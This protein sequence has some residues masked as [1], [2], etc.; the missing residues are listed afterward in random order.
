MQIPIL[1][2]SLGDKS[3]SNELK[4]ES[5]R[6]RNIIASTQLSSILEHLVFQ[7]MVTVTILRQVSQ[8]SDPYSET[9]PCRD[10]LE[11]TASHEFCKRR[12]GLLKVWSTM[13]W[14]DSHVNSA[15][16]SRVASKVTYVGQEWARLWPRAKG[17]LAGSS[18]IKLYTERVPRL[19]CRSRGRSPCCPLRVVT[20]KNHMVEWMFCPG[21]EKMLGFS[22]R[23]DKLDRLCL[24]QSVMVCQMTSVLCCWNHQSICIGLAHIRC[25]HSAL[26][27]FEPQ[28]LHFC[29][30]CH[31]VQIQPQKYL[32]TE[33]WIHSKSIPRYIPDVLTEI[34]HW[35][36]RGRPFRRVVGN[37]SLGFFLAEKLKK[38]S[39][40]SC[41]IKSPDCPAQSVKRSSLSRGS[42]K[43]QFGLF[44][45]WEIKE[46]IIGFLY[47]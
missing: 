46:E 8:T 36:Q 27:L 19:E 30:Q 37:C 23:D 44:L 42:G 20:A 34:N 29:K 31:T 5:K 16:Q 25:C 22:Q 26:S 14:E 28:I 45:G 21:H 2:L 3:A 40:V 38:R 24:L 7:T 41:T 4:L 33:K 6:G 47:T 39:L 32:S 1:R 9:S 17:A 11:A 13:S 15:S 35:Q 18:R 12:L 43:P 10:S